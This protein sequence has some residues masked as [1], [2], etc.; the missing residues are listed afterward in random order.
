MGGAEI[1]LFILL[2]LV[3]FVMLRPS[4][5]RNR[6]PSGAA[7]RYAWAAWTG[8]AIIAMPGIITLSSLAVPPKPGI[9][10]AESDSVIV[11]EGEPVA[12][13]A[14]AEAFLL[15]GIV[16]VHGNE[17]RTIDSAQVVVPA[18]GG[19]HFSFED[20]VQLKVGLAP[21]SDKLGRKRVKIDYR[22]RTPGRTGSGSGSIGGGEPFFVEDG[23]PVYEW[24]TIRDRVNSNPFGSLLSDGSPKSILLLITPLQNEEAVRMVPSPEWREEYGDRIASLARAASARGNGSRL[25]AESSDEI[26]HPFLA[27]SYS[28]LLLLVLGSLFLLFATVHKVRTICLV[29]IFCAVYTGVVDGLVLTIQL[30]RLDEDGK[31]K[32]RTAAVVGVAGT[33][34]HPFSAVDELF[35]TARSGKSSA[36]RACA[37]RCLDRAPL[38]AAIREMSDKDDLLDSFA[39]E[40]DDEIAEAAK[41]I[42]EKLE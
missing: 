1:L 12:D 24:I 6:V 41:N 28:G 38:L 39:S 27:L 35:E 17:E 42:I 14:D 34:M 5:F 13:P 22:L 37:L 2:V 15:R 8:V 20:G 4:R 9:C 21:S 23:Y 19:T 40:G 26:T 36:V 25:R 29:L 18:N 16:S 32:V 33:R 30:G 3:V 7:K 11:P 10:F 31:P